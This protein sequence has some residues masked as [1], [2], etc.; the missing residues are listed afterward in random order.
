MRGVAVADK[1][2]DVGKRRVRFADQGARAVH[3]NV[4]EQGA[5]AHALAVK[6]S[7]QR[8]RPESGHAGG[9]FKVRAPI[10]QTQRH[11]RQKPIYIAFGVAK[12]DL[13]QYLGRT[14]R[15]RLVVAHLQPSSRPERC[16][17]KDDL[18]PA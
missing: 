9:P 10:E 12:A 17:R 7:L 14:D 1:I 11:D 13:G 5:I 8:A 4:V 18:R 16:R 2:G 15:R 3:A 6:P